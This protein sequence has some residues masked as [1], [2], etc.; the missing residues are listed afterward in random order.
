MKAI[1]TA[2]ETMQLYSVQQLRHRGMF[3]TLFQVVSNCNTALRLYK[4]Q[5]YPF[6]QLSKN[7]SYTF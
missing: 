4:F 5:P 6:L 1:S 7:I 3:Y 2:T